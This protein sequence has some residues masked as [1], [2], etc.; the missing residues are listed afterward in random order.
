MILVDVHAHLENL[1]FKD[2][3]DQVIQ[4]AKQAGVKAIITNGIEPEAN[5]LA[6]E[7]AKKYDIV[8]AALGIYPV[9]ALKT[10]A[11][12]GEHNKKPEP[13]DFDKE[14]DFISTNKDN[15]VAIG[16]IGLDYKNSDKKEE[17][18][19]HFL[20]LLSLAEKLEKPVIVHS[21]R[22]ENDVVDVI[23]TTNVKKVILH[24][25]SGKQ[26]LVKK[27]LDSGW[28]F[29]IPTNIVR[30]QQFQLIAQTASMS[31]ILTETDAPYLSP[32]KGQKNEPS[33]VIETVKKIAEIKELEPEEVANNIYMNYQRIFQN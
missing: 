27:A 16:E 15:I 6:L 24:C 26:K 2:D 19:Q 18:K 21:R 13:F 29:S 12:T 28:N 14:L 10:E 23:Q 4:R 17:Q 33:F 30:S 20:K 8:K 11:E 3:L 1:A 22:A 25:F 31:Q 5:R 32:Y 9:D 7:I